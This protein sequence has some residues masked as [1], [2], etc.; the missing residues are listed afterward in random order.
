MRR[1]ARCRVSAALVC[2]MLVLSVC[3]VV[4]SALR[5]PGAGTPAAAMDWRQ[6]G[7]ALGV[8][9]AL[10]AAIAAFKLIGF[11]LSFGLLCFFIVAVM[12]R[13]PLRVAAM[14]ALAGAAGSYLVF[15]FALGVA[16][17]LGVFGF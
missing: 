16:L 9:L 11:V 6:T 3:L 10:V 8:W 13:R 7:R 2:A 1:A 4:S 12:Y 14:V 5:K 17:P 15:P